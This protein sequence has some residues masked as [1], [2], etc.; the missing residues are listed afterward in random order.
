MLVSV[1]YQMFMHNY[2]PWYTHA[3]IL[4]AIGSRCARKLQPPSS[5]SVEKIKNEKDP[6]RLTT[7]WG[8]TYMKEIHHYCGF[9]VLKCN[10]MYKF[11]FMW[12]C[13]IWLVCHMT[14]KFTWKLL[15]RKKNQFS[16]HN[17]CISNIYDLRNLEKGT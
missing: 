3:Y 17:I 11:L 5:W 9:T 10:V 8:R 13:I 4:N 16:L 15:S 12:N 14:M 2:K 6:K 1:R 7:N